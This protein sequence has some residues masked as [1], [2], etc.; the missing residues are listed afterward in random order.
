MKA[1]RF[2]EHGGPEVLRYEDAPD[3]KIE[4]NEVLVKVKAC[5]LNHL[6]LFLRAGVRSWTLPMPHIVGSDISGVVAEAGR[7]TTRVKPGDRV[8]LAPGVSCGQCEM[9]WK[10]LDSACRGYTLLGVMVDGGYAEY[11]KAPEANAILIPADF[12]FDE[13]AAVPLVFLTAWHMLMTRAQL[14]LGEE[15][16]VI[17]AGSGVGT[18]AIQL[19]KLM[20]ARVIAVAG[21]DEKLEKARALGADEVVNHRKQS[22]AEEVKRLT[23]RRGVDVIVEHVGAAVW[24]ACFDSLATYGR[25]VTCGTTSGENVELNLRLLFGRQRTLMGSFMGGKG[26]LAGVLKFVFAGKVH[27]V[28]DSEF[29]LRDAAAAQQ[30]MDG[31][32]FFGKILLHPEEG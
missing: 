15:V 23:G 20:Q 28:I 26:E 13:A 29:P 24:D 31:R 10:G 21:S 14:R 5:A 11:V 27:A 32:E 19:A 8:L 2:H 4:A 16:L 12:S 22:I 25:L 9:C 3:P 17:G 18:A 1:V 7:L 6:D 30:R